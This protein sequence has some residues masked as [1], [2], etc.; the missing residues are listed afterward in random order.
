MTLPPLAATLAAH[1]LVP[2]KS[3]GQHFLLDE[4]LLGSIVASAGDLTG[5]HVVE[6]GPGPGGLTRALLAGP[7]ASVTVIE[8]D[9]RFLPLLE[10]L[11]VHAGE[12][13][14]IIARDALT[15]DPLALTPEPRAILANLPYNIGTEL[16]AHWLEQLAEHGAASY[17][18]ITVMLQEEVA[19]RLMA[20]PG[21]KAYGRLS[22]L[23]RWL[24]EPVLLRRVPPGA[25]TPPP[26]VMSAVIQ[27]RP[28]PHPLAEADARTLIRVVAAAVTAVRACART[29]SAAKS[30][31]VGRNSSCL[32]LLPRTTAA[33]RSGSPSFAASATGSIAR[34]F[35]SKMPAV[36]ATSATLPW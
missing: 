7:A 25:F 28:R 34:T 3:L 35:A 30:A 17:R 8:K 4:G 31:S 24:T 29:P 22:V 23:A 14:Q 2:K 20:T 1:G 6:I 26:S 10:E 15:C 18:H 36:D 16:V 12:R 21:S 11:R 32:L 13:L 19:E 5:I 9:T 33:T 27:L